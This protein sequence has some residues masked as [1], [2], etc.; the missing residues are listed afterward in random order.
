MDLQK[1]GSNFSGAQ[2][3]IQEMSSHPRK[4]PIILKQT[5]LL[6]ASLTLQF[7]YHKAKIKFLNARYMVGSREY[8]GNS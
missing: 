1:H 5:N 8:S 3:D 2:G 4:S 6:S 7:V